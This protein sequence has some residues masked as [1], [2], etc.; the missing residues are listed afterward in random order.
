MDTGCPTIL[1]TLS[2]VMKKKITERMFKMMETLRKR[3]VELKNNPNPN[4]YLHTNYD[5]HKVKQLE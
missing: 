5:I 4:E 3:I 1:S 2:H